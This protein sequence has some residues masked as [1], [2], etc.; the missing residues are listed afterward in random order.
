MPAPLNPRLNLPKGIRDIVAKSAKGATVM[1]GTAMLGSPPYAIDGPALTGQLPVSRLSTPDTDRSHVLAPDGSGGLTTRAEAGNVTAGFDG[2]GSPLAGGA[3]QDVAIRSARTI[4]S[5]T[6]IADQ[7]GAVT[8]GVLRGTLAD[9]IAGSPPAASLTAAN[10][11]EL[12]AEV[13]ATDSTLTGWT[14]ALAAGDVVRFVLSAVDGVQTK[15][16]LELVT[17]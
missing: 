11:P 3:V 5:W 1:G 2:G 12:A 8:I 17:T 6:L 16:T 4:T 15:V 10:D 13:A 7:V 14:T 9:L